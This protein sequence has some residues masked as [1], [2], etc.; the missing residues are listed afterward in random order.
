[1]ELN[2]SING[3]A[4]MFAIIKRDTHSQPLACMEKRVNEREPHLVQ[5]TMNDEM[6]YYIRAFTCV[7]ARGS[8]PERK[9]LDKHKPCSD[10]IFDNNVYEDDDDG[11]GDDEIV[12]SE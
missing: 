1:M 12:V 11:D 2:T 5:S 9:E 4:P 7:C 3:S 6:I 8:E 10:S